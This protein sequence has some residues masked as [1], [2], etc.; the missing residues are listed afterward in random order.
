MPYGKDIYG[1]THL[2]IGREGL[3]FTHLDTDAKPVH[4]FTKKIDG[5]YEVG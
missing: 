4:R 5:S 1:F 3:T 2:R